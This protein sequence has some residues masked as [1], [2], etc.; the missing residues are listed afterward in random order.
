[1]RE[2][3]SLFYALEEGEKINKNKNKITIFKTKT[4]GVTIVVSGESFE[5]DTK[6]RS[7]R[8]LNGRRLIGGSGQI[9]TVLSGN[10][11]GGC[12]GGGLNI[13]TVVILIM[14]RERET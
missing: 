8:C 14:R 1:M 3:W 5:D 6:R 12:G 7:K 10:I 9:K 13:G 2:S 11:Y 4:S